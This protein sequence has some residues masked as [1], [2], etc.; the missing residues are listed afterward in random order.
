M[1]YIEADIKMK[2]KM[3]SGYLSAS[4]TSILLGLSLLAASTI[5]NAQSITVGGANFSEQSILANIYASALRAQGIEVATRL[6]LGN[7]QI[8]AKALEGGDIDVAPEYI[9]SL[10]SF[11]DRKTQLTDQ[12][13]IVSALHEKL[14]EGLKLLEPSSAGST[15]AWAVTKKTAD[16]YGL[17]TLSDLA[18]VSKD[19]TLG[20]PPEVTTSAL[21]LPGLKA[22]YGIDF[23]LVKS[24]DMGGPLTRLA[25][26]SGAIDVAT[27]V[28]SQGIL[29]KESWVV[30]EDDRHQ[31]PP[32]NIAPLIRKSSLDPVVVKALDDVS[33]KLTNDDLKELN[34]LVDIDHKDPAKVA[35]QWVAKNTVK[36]AN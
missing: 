19:L 16:K 2:I 27:V 22:V 34:R 24:L 18:A 23:K 1:L 9:G 25:L 33:Q 8:I 10:L 30:L 5:A 21:G 26:N 36:V 32:Q 7:R 15:T 14:P 17:H 13:D 29:A 3:L 20:G 11:H 31:Q 6:N 35:E 4:S 28:S 12:K